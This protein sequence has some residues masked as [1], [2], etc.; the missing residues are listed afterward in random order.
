M[1]LIILLFYV[2]F[3]IVYSAFYGYVIKRIWEF[4][5]EGDKSRE[6]IIVF[7]LCI[8]AVLIVSILIIMVQFAR[9]V[10]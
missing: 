7:L 4:R 2:L 10:S 6:S 1:E 5:I 3:V 9:G 8:G